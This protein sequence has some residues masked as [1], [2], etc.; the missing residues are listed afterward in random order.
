MLAPPLRH[1]EPLLAPPA[2]HSLSVDLPAILAQLMMRAAIP[3]PRTH[4]RELAQ[5][6]PQRRIICG[7][8]GLPALHG[9]ML[10]YIPACPALADAQAIAEHRDRLV[11]AGRAYQLPLEISSRNSHNS[12]TDSGGHATVADR[13]DT[14]GLIVVGELIDDP[15]RADAQRAQPS[16]LCTAICAP[17][18]TRPRDPSWSTC[19][20]D[21]DDLD[22]PT[23]SLTAVLSSRFSGW[24][25]S[26][27]GLRTAS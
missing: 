10:A 12:R 20:S 4:L 21:P 26:S 9:A 27:A 15:V 5:P 7:A 8:L 18:G 11:P 17:N 3:P 6:S 1:P 14:D 13:R 25:K 16:G 24:G 19:R 22:V 23:R 2:L